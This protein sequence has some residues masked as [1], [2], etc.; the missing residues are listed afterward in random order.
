M[1]VLVTGADGF[2]G[3]FLVRRLVAAG[4]EV[5]A[6]VR[7][8]GAPP[9]VWLSPAEAR[10]VERIDFELDDT[11][12]A[13]TAA[14][15]G[16]DGVVHLAA[17]ASSREARRD[18]GLAW[19]VNAAG[20]ARLLEQLAG[21]RERG[22]SDPAVIVVSSGEV[23][24]DGPARPRLETDPVRPQSPYA[25][26]KAG[27]E[28]GALEVARRTGLRVVIARAFQH[29]GPG[30]SD[31]YVVP[32]LARRL[33]A[34]RRDGRRE[35]T[36]G[37]LEPVRDITDVRDVVAA[38][39]ALLERGAPGEVYNVARGEGIALRDVFTR[40]AAALGLDAVPVADPSL[41]RSGDIPHLV[42][43]PAKLRAAT[44]WT[45]A[46]TIDQ[47]LRDVLDAQAD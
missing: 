23:Y 41:A 25:A 35:V 33:A 46:Y 21:A 26:T 39:I 16:A 1:K 31:T 8:G 5:G 13:E 37:N 47:T 14:A 42:G 3:R 9:A 2:V 27:A 4:H 45:P 36:T 17:V 32:A 24:G 11:G 19:T 29:T 44:G 40:L 7:R 43:D 30:Q 34:A 10:A 20:T 15:W 6:A 38:Y 12:T 18:P 22:G 28:I